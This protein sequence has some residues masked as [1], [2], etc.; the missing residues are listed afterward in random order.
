[1]RKYEE[2]MAHICVTPAMRARVLRRVRQSAARRTAWRRAAALAACLAVAVLGALVL[3]SVRQPADD[4]G[5]VL[6]PGPTQA[7]S[8]E[9]LSR[10][11]RKSVV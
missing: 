5:G 7:A 11:D 1:M 10:L 4:V 2:A 6:A 3:P 9:E 8:A